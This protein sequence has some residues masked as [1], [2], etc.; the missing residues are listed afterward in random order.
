M[1]S[2]EACGAASTDGCISACGASVAH[3]AC[4]DASTS[5]LE[6]KS[7]KARFDRFMA[8]TPA[9]QANARVRRCHRH[10]A[11]PRQ[12]F[13]CNAAPKP[14]GPTASTAGAPMARRVDSHRSANAHPYTTGG[15]DNCGA[16]ARRP[17]GA[18]L[19]RARTGVAGGGGLLIAVP[20]S[21]PLSGTCLLCATSRL[22][23]ARRADLGTILGAPAPRLG[24]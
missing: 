11:A 13:I 18:W 23:A 9:G 17:V 6:T 10:F 22:G 16:V 8:A 21:L 24:Q 15:V 3:P 2:S 19:P 14:A 5:E 4:T 20:L 1:L 7:A 12:R